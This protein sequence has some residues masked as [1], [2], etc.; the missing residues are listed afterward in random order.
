[1]NYIQA[2]NYT[3]VASRT[4]DLLVIHDMEFPETL[5]AAEDV[6]RY[7][8]RQEKGPNGSSAHYCLDSNSAVHCVRDHDV[9]WAAP[10]ANHDGLHFEFAGY[11]KQTDK[12]WRDKYDEA[13]LDIAARLFARKAHQYHIP[14]AHVGPV[15]LRHGYSGITTHREITESGI[16]G[17]NANHQDP[18]PNFPL[19]DFLAR[20]REHYNAMY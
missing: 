9:A 16:G 17:P 15:H 13:M 5:T 20:V 14:V 7:F 19:A 10:G 18:G 3:P 8:A 11:A 4:I 6:A 12:Q 2:R 1:M